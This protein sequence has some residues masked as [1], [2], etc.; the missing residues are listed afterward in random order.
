MRLSLSMPKFIFILA[1]FGF[2]ILLKKALTSCDFRAF[3][4]LKMKIEGKIIVVVPLYGNISNV[5]VDRLFR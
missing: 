5:V 2:F 4:Y 3:C 1:I